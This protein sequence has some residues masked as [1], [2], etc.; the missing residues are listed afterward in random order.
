MKGFSVYSKK[1][2]KKPLTLK[3]ATDIRIVRRGLGLLYLFDVTGIL[4]AF[5]RKLYTL[6]IFLILIMITLSVLPSFQMFANHMKYIDF[7]RIA[8]GVTLAIFS[9]EIEEYF[10][11]K[12]GYKMQ[13]FIL[14]QNA[15]EASFK[16]EE[17]LKLSTKPEVGF[18]AR[19][20]KK[21]S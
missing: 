4:Y 21:K 1:D 20:F 3:E 13:G 5:Y 6:G 8:L 17:Q 11:S 15:K 7:A 14:A 19:R 9:V 10:L 2:V 12:R 16:I 18:F